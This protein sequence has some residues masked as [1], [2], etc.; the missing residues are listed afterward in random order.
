MQTGIHQGSAK[1][2]ELLFPTFTKEDYSLPLPGS[3]LLDLEKVDQLAKELSEKIY[4]SPKNAKLNDVG[5]MVPEELGVKLNEKEFKSQFVEYFYQNSQSNM[6]IPTLSVYPKVDSELLSH[7]KNKQIGYY[8]TYFNSHNKTRSHNIRLS[9]EAINNHVVFP[10]E[11]FSFNEVVG[12][13]TEAKG[14]LKA[15]VIVRGELSEGIGG[16]ICQVSSTLFNAVDRAGMDIIERYSHSK[17]VPYVPPGRDATV[18]WYGPDFSFKNMT[19]QPILIRSKA[20][21]GTI[22]VMIYS[23]DLINNEPRNVQSMSIDLPKEI[24]LSD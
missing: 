5:Q 2:N 3:P 7:I 22:F 19:N 6:K 17:S 23:S 4:V 24:H 11:K 1:E 12:R 9:A 21:G 14:Y 13:R 10:G 20:V 15:P 18:S 8:V 16:G